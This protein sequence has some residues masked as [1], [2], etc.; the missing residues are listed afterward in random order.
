MFLPS[1]HCHTP[2]G[3]SHLPHTTLPLHYTPSCSQHLC[4]YVY[5]RTL[6]QFVQTRALRCRH[7][8]RTPC[9]APHNRHGKPAT[10]AGSGCPRALS[11]AF[12]LPRT[13]RLQ[14]VHC[15]LPASSSPHLP[16]YIFASRALQF[17]F[18]IFWRLPTYNASPAY[19][20]LPLLN[21]HSLALTTLRGYP[22]LTCLR[23]YPQAHATGFTAATHTS[24]APSDR[25]RAC[26]CGT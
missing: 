2:L 16:H 3:L 4:I 17:I 12:Y 24:R 21:D 18:F 23:H 9:A 19:L 14:P 26:D 8:L 10:P 20:W 1:G 5:A 11:P 7:T 6:L 22:T 25:L 13:Y 15:H